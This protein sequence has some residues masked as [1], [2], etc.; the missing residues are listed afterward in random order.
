M[1]IDQDIK[2]EKIEIDQKTS[3]EVDKLLNRTNPNKDL[4]DGISLL[5]IVK[6]EEKNISD[7]LNS[8]KGLVDQLILVDTGCSDKTVEIAKAICDELKID[9]QPANYKWND[10]FAEA[11]N[12]GI[13]FSNYKWIIWLDADDRLKFDIQVLRQMVLKTSTNYAFLLDVTSEQ[14][15]GLIDLASQVR[16][17]PNDGKCRFKKRVHEFVSAPH[18]QGVTTKL[19]IT[20]IGY[21][22][23]EILKQKRI[24]NL[25]LLKMDRDEIENIYFIGLYHHNNDN[26]Y[27][28][29][30]CFLY[31]LQE[32]GTKEPMKDKC[33]SLIGMQFFKIKKYDLAK[34]FFEAS[35]DSDAKYRLAELYLVENDY[36]NA[37]KKFEEYLNDSRPSYS[38]GTMRQTF[39]PLALKKL[40][41]ISTK[42]KEYWE[43]KIWD[44]FK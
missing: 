38:M 43:S 19:V 27:K 21:K 31:L 44:E 23:E 37:K 18:C 15:G 20:H 3:S 24:R 30:G 14:P 35:N 10:H 26:P 17:F 8:V 7:C 34:E 12:S 33:K 2:E 25:K 1:R 6:D 28:A 32:D 13:K 5:M 40:Q 11:R 4:K 42:E 39:G 29:M 9:F 41:E 22:D 36:L 16:I